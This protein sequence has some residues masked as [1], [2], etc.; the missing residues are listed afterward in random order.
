VLLLAINSRISLN[1]KKIR[2]EVQGIVFIFAN[3]LCIKSAVK[4]SLLTFLHNVL[5]N[6]LPEINKK[7]NNEGEPQSKKLIY[8]SQKKLILLIGETKTKNKVSNV[9]LFSYI[10]AIIEA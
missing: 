9:C 8:C 1:A 10:A 3:S 6:S 4:F 5:A 7:S 2:P